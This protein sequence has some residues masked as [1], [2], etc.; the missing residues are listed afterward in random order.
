MWRAQRLP[1]A[2][3]GPQRHLQKPWAAWPARLMR[4]RHHRA[5]VHAVCALQEPSWQLLRVS[6][7]SALM[8]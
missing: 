1:W 5:A 6:P 4:G 3:P 8:L 7:T 2:N